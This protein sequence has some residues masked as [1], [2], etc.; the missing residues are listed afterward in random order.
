MPNWYQKIWNYEQRGS[1]RITNLRAFRHPWR[2]VLGGLD[3]LHTIAGV[4]HTD[5]KPENVVVVDSSPGDFTKTRS[6]IRVEIVDF[7][8]ARKISK[9]IGGMGRTQEYRAPEMVLLAP[10]SAPVDIWATACLAFELSTRDY[11]FD[12]HLSHGSVTRDGRSPSFYHRAPST[13]IP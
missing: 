3:F 2:Q 11:L 12:P 9:T 7:G 13:T 10:N 1:R 5:I 6:R 4:V 8:N